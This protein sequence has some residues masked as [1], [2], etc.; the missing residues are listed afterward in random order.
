MRGGAYKTLSILIIYSLNELHVH[1]D[2]VNGKNLNL[3]CLSI[4]ILLRKR[5]YH[6][7]KELILNLEREKEREKERERVANKKQNR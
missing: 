4:E 3:C 1:E 2:P 7:N 5:H 6:M